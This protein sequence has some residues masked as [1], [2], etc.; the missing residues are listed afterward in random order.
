MVKVSVWMEGTELVVSHILPDSTTFGE[1]REA[2][3]DAS[4]RVQMALGIRERA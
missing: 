4:Q 3:E 1:A 2:L